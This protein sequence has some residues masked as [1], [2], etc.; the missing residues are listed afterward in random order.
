VL[1]R[2]PLSLVVDYVFLQQ[3]KMGYIIGLQNWVIKS[4]NDTIIGE[5]GMTKILRKHFDVVDKFI[6]F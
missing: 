5:S 3:V 4:G 1:W 6:V 2:P